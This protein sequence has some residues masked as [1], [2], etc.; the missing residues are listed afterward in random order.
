MKLS[1]IK[2][3]IELRPEPAGE[4]QPLLVLKFG[5]SVLRDIGDLP[6]VAGEIYRQRRKGYRIIAVVS[7]LEGET[8]L[9][10][11]EAESV[12]GN[13]DCAG[14]AELV[15]L[16]EE[17]AAALVKLAC[18]KIGIKTRICRVEELSLHTSGD[19]LDADYDEL[20]PWRIK[21][22]L[23][24]TGVVIVPGFVGIGVEGERMLLGRGG[25]DFTAAILGGELGAEAVRLYK[26]VDGVFEADP[27]TNP[28]A[29]KFA[30][31]GYSDALKIA[32]KL[33]HGKAVEFAAARNLRI[34]VEALGSD[35]PTIIGLPSSLAAA[36]Q[37]LPPLRIALAGYGVVGQALAARIWRDPRFAISSILVRDI[38]R[39]RNI[40]PPVRLTS[41][42][43]EFASAPADVLVELLSCDATGAALCE[44]KLEDGISVVTASKRVIA[45]HLT[46]LGDTARAANARLCNSG[47]VGGGTPILEAI[48]Q[49]RTRG[50]I[51]EISAILNGTVNFVLGRL[52]RG[53]ALDQA[54]A[55]ARNLG[56]AEEDASADLGGADAAAKLKIIA[57]RAFG[58]DPRGVE[59]DIEA[60]DEKLARLIQAS[61][62]RWVQHSQVRKTNKGIAAKVCFRPA[63]QVPVEP[64]SDEWNTARIELEDG[65][66]FEVIGR[67]AGG[68]AT[69]EAVLADLY[70][71]LERRR[72]KAANDGERKQGIL[73]DLANGGSSAF[74]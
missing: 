20:V 6:R 29:R 38:S 53:M 61:G 5:S 37:E 2:D 7:A 13:I 11:A 21:H 46:L 32:G 63:E 34:E 33:V 47:A 45:Q 55:L 27:A 18:E 9:L 43:E 41:S 62:K 14:K 44:T 70:D 69:A 48:D 54:L 4:A 39:R 19:E 58:V 17:R 65:R 31:V 36:T 16:G 30:Q 52:N 24:E 72:L 26:D 15:S 66:S 51:A 42:L 60:L 35:E 59:V 10:F 28:A 8:D 23:A 22:H 3:E 25:T 50:S 40:V 49:A 74:V 57:A 1:A 12:T 64:V 71:L 56:F 73:E 67:G 68:A